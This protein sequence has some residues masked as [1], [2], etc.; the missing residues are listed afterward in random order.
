MHRRRWR[1]LTG[2]PVRIFRRSV[3]FFVKTSRKKA[4][5]VT[6]DSDSVVTV[7]VVHT[8]SL[9]TMSAP[10]SVHEEKGAGRGSGKGHGRKRNPRGCDGNVMTCRVCN[11]EEHFAARCPQGKGGGNGAGSS[12]PSA[13]FHVAEGR[14]AASHLAWHG[15]E[16]EPEK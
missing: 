13:T 15:F 14:Q 6:T 3:R 9:R 4:K 7:D 2:K 12:F 5:D 8:S 16:A 11:S 1:R 10:T